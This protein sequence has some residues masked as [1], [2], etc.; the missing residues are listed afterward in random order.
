MRMPAWIA[1]LG[2]LTLAAAPLAAQDARLARLDPTTGAVVARL[3]DSARAA[4][5][6]DEPLVDKALE[7]ASKRAAGARIADAVRALLVD[8]GRARDALGGGSEAELTAGAAA[9]RAGVAPGTLGELRRA[10]GAEALSVPLATLAD[11][12]SRGVPVET[13]QAVVVALAARGVSD[14][15]YVELRRVVEADIGAGVPPAAAASVRAQ[16][17]RP[18]DKVV[19]PGQT[20][21]KG[22]KKS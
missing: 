8:L 12:V 4:G 18:P 5:L 10:R 13:A 14:A 3:V 9:L 15:G 19:P 1:L 11:L 6:P 21:G 20:R 16:G 2:G 7:G 17:G 22:V